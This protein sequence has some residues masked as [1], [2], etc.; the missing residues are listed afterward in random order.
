MWIDYDQPLSLPLKF[1]LSQNKN[2]SFQL[3][4]LNQK[5]YLDYVE[6]SVFFNWKFRLEQYNISYLKILELNFAILR[7]VPWVWNVKRNHLSSKYG[8]TVRNEVVLTKIGE[9]WKVLLEDVKNRKQKYI[10]DKIWENGI[11]LLALQGKMQGKSITGRRSEL[12]TTNSPVY[13]PCETFREMI[14]CARSH[15]I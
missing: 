8:R 10:V 4:F 9:E 11:F 7:L 14:R 2:S 6:K 13:S 15:L 12:V 1:F 3:S 5:I